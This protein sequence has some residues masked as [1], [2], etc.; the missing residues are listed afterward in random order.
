MESALSETRSKYFQ[1]KESGSPLSS[2]VIQHISSPIPNSDGP[3]VSRSDVRSNENKN[4]ERPAR[5]VRSLFRDDSVVAKRNDLSESRRRIP[6][7]QLGSV[8]DLTTENEFL[9]NEF[10]HQQHPFSD[11]LDMTEEDQNSI[12]V[13][14]YFSDF[15]AIFRNLFLSYMIIKDMLIVFKG[16]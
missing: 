2:P 11:S 9:V 1:S 13:C 4:A 6:D 16:L 10:L 14:T 3:P 12:K 7:G 8:G 5:V 15:F